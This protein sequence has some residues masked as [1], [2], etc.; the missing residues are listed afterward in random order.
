MI[1]TVLSVKGMACEGCE[2]RVKDIIS[3]EYK[4]K[5]VT[6]SFKKGEVEIISEDA[7]DK[8]DIKTRIEAAGF[9][10]ISVNDEPY[11]KKGFSFFRK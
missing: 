8:S 10:V 7:I 5:K 11:E 2:N 3:K 9:E 4:V 1:K 6:A